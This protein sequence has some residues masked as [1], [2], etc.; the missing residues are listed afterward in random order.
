METTLWVVMGDYRETFGK[1]EGIFS[2][3]ELAQAF[4]DAYEPKYHRCDLYVESWV[5]DQGKS[6]EV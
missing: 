4:I 5:L 2:T 1:L 6:V 3:P